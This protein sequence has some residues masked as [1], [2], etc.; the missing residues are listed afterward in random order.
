MTKQQVFEMLERKQDHTIDEVAH[1]MNLSPSTV[2]YWLRIA[3]KEGITVP[4]NKK[5]GRKP[6][7]L[8]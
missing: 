3:R 8:K 6:L 1:L 4:P 2:R 7:I 5:A